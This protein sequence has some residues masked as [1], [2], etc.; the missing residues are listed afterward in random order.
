MK[1]LLLLFLI[2]SNFLL[3]SSE[4]GREYTKNTC[5]RTYW[6][7]YL[8]T[9]KER[10]ECSECRFS[11]EE[12]YDKNWKRYIASIAYDPS[13]CYIEFL[14]VAEDF[15]K[16]GI[17]SDLAKRAIE[18]MRINHDCKEISLYS[19]TSARKFWEKAGAIPTDIGPTHVFPDSSSNLS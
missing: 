16:Q 2:S 19:A 6:G 10:E 8:T 18:D 3:L 5:N 1:K 9:D 7:G 11:R 12:V 14:S 13:R 17:G 15:R 4:N